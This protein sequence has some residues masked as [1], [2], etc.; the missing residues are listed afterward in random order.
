MKELK[1]R[2]KAKTPNFSKKIQK[3]A[4]AL[5]AAAAIVVAAPITLPALVV[6]IAGYVVTAG[7]VA[8]TL[9]QLTVEN[10]KDI[11]KVTNKTK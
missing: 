7:T 6:T 11:T 8:A 3:V 4:I 2:W 10:Y 9:S 1:G 5:G